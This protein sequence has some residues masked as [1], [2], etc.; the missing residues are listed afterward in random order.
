MIWHGMAWHR[1]AWN[2]MRT[3]EMRWIAYRIEYTNHN[4]T[5][6]SHH[7][8]QP[9]NPSIHPWVGGLLART[10]NPNS[11]GYG[12]QTCNANANAMQCQLFNIDPETE[13]ELRN[14][15][16]RTKRN[17][18]KKTKRSKMTSSGSKSH[19]LKIYSSF[20]QR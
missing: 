19:D 20:L 15:E 10:S 2:G 4:I 11:I 5:I 18:P 9:S 14:T 7:C 12:T 3:D 13:F 6:P 16:N 17:N 8:T 1:M